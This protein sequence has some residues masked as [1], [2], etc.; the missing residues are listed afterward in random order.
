MCAKMPF[1][2]RGTTVA[3][4]KKKKSIFKRWWFWLL[5]ILV[6]LYALGSSEGSGNST[7]SR[8]GSAEPARLAAPELPAPEAAFIGTIAR[9]QASSKSAENDMQRGGIKASRDR[10][11]CANMQS[12]SV[13]DWVGKVETV[14][15]NSDGKGVLAV[16]IAKDVT[17]KTWNNALSD[18]MHETLIPPGTKLFADASALKRGQMVKFSGTFFAGSEGD[19]VSESSLSLTGKL[20]DPEFIFRFSAVAPL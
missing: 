6:G 8:S 4:E 5:A 9:A 15:A 2:F 20:K 16:E 17:V 12:K 3:E 18:I 10:E 11:L 1:H 14:S 19:C 13:R 7:P